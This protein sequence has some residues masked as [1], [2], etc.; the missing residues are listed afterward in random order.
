MAQESPITHRRV[1]WIALPIVL[2]NATVPLMGLVDTFAVGQ[3]GAAA[4]IGAVAVGAVI[5]TAVYWIFGFL[6]MGTTG[7]VAQAA[8]SGDLDERD[9]LLSRALLIAGV[10]GVSLI[11][12][13]VPLMI[14]AFK[15]SPASAEVEGLA[16]TYVAIRIWGAPAAIAIYALTGWL[17]A[18]ER[19]R[20][21]LVL[22][23]AMNGGNIALTLLFVLGLDMGVGGAALA[24]LIAEWAGA[25]LGLWLCRE[26]FRSGAWRDRSRVLDRARIIPMMAAN[27]D[28]MIRS[29]LLQICFI[30]VT[31]QAAALSDVTLAANQILL[32]FLYI[33]ANALDGFAFAAEALVGSA[34]GA[35]NV[36]RLR[37]AA[38]L[39]SLWALV[40]VGVLSLTY[41]FAGEEII[42]QMTTATAVQEAAR[43]YLPWMVAA[44]L[45]GLPCFMLDGI[46]IGAVRTRDMRNM[47]LLSALLFG[48]SLLVLIP[49]YGNHGL[50]AALM[51]FFIIRAITLGAKYPALE[52][53]ALGR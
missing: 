33:T 23:L 11:A 19:T 12:L 39:S 45:L 50:W 6:R 40:M 48:A 9:A 36:A 44:P 35:G 47:M 30:S 38:L 25:A 41:A 43:T 27:T 34:F 42:G 13:Q 46:F 5:L 31:F 7:M 21:V 26:A 51:L 29:V 15:L 52:R 17:I 2:S 22:Q 20:A 4:P 1:L 14:G 28:I 37:R 8:G 53:A 24:T 3:L 32:Q 49:A 16:R 18:L 10:A